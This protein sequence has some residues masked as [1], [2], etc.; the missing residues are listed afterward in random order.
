MS[1]RLR[2][3]E[4][5]VTYRVAGIPVRS[6]YP[7][8]AL[9]PFAVPSANS[10]ESG[11][12]GLS[13]PIDLS[14]L[15]SPQAS[16]AIRLHTEALS[17]YRFSGHI[18]LGAASYDLRAW[19]PD[20]EICMMQARRNQPENGGDHH[21]FVVDAR[22]VTAAR[23]SLPGVPAQGRPPDECLLLGPALAVSLAMR[24]IFLLHASAVLVDGVVC[25]FLAPSGAGKSTLAAALAAQDDVRGL[26]DD[27]VP[28]VARA[29]KA[30]SLIPEFPQ[31]KWPPA[32]QRRFPQTAVR[33]NIRWFFIHP[34][35]ADATQS[36]AIEPLKPAVVML[37]LARHGVATR[38][39][40]PYWLRQHQ[41]A[42]QRA[43]SLPGMTLHYPHRPENLAIACDLVRRYVQ[44]ASHAL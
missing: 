5:K 3:S 21:T 20:D 4:T 15:Q 30:V 26:A 18:T 12:S 40:N 14:L 1:Q 8:A 28:M 23:F 32:W 10:S 9:A 22:G 36:V 16:F 37:N 13:S 34:L 41:Q 44:E 38:L 35:A 19:W 17:N 27:I 33:Q 29:D 43:A 7:V 42:C 39:L 31:W 11:Q 24:G 2:V 6:A 25:V